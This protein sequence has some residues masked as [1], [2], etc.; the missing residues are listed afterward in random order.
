MTNEQIVRDACRFIWTDGDLSRISEFYSEDFQADYPV[1]NWGT[2]LKGVKDIAI[3]QR[4]AFPDY[5]EQIDEL[6]N[7]GDQV[8]VVLTIR[9]THLGPLPNLPATGKSMEIRDVSI[10]QV[11]DGKIVKQS[12]VSDYFTAYQQLGVFDLQHDDAVPTAGT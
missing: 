10:I 2:G 8:I 4:E 11:K 5:R 1:T 3:M 12:G 9:G 6:I 7:A